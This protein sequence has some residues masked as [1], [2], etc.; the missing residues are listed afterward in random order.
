MPQCAVKKAWRDR[1]PMITIAIIIIAIYRVPILS[2]IC[3]VPMITIIT[4][5]E[6]ILNLSIP[7]PVPSSPGEEDHATAQDFH[8]I[9]VHGP[10]GS[11]SDCMTAT[12]FIWVYEMYFEHTK[13]R[14][15]SIRVQ[16]SFVSHRALL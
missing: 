6:R 9:E 14:S 7:A 4:H 8:P 2:L 3:R 5:C 13:R 15:G 11:Q 1:V 16:R 10:G 12:P